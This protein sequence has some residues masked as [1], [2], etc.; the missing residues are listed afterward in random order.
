VLLSAVV[1]V[2]GF[3]LAIMS[4]V[5]AMMKSSDAYKQALT[6]A[7][8]SPAV[9][10]ALGTPITEGYFTSGSINVSGPSGSADLA[11]PIS[12]PKGEATIYVEARKSAGEWTYSALVVQIGTTHQRINLLQGKQK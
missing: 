8:E 2:G 11:I 7:K 10:Y 1:L 3:V 6:K 5:S 4:F 12:G 9:L